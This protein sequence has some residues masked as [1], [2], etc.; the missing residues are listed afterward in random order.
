MTSGNQMPSY[1]RDIERLEREIRKLW[2]SLNNTAPP[3]T[4]PETEIVWSWGGALDGD[5]TPGPRWR[6]PYKCRIVSI[7][8]TAGV[9]GSGTSQFNLYLNNTLIDSFSILAG[10]TVHH[11]PF[12]L[13]LIGTDVV[14]VAQS[15]TYSATC[16]N[17]GVIARYRKT[18]QID[19]L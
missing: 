7:T 8:I 2:A 12:L 11:H 10:E 3:P 17:V 6:V 14:H 18:Q 5:T 16:T 4:N 1:R 19:P 13:D 9:A 15:G